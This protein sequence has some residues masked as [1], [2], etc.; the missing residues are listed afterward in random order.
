MLDMGFQK[1]LQN[2]SEE[3]KDAKG[4]IFSA[5]VPLWI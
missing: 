3:M 2:I 1:E 4:M 5:T